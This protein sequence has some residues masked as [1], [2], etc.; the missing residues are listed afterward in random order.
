MNAVENPIECEATV[1]PAINLSEVS[2]HQELRRTSNTDGASTSS[3][4]RRSSHLV[5]AEAGPST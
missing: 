5:C 2:N 4:A 1:V 3:S